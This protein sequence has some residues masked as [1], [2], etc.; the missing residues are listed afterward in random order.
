MVSPDRK[1]CSVQYLVSRTPGRHM[2]VMH[3]LKMEYAFFF[4]Y[5]HVGLYHQLLEVGWPEPDRT[6]SQ[7][8]ENPS[9]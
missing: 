8:L 5:N 9:R 6:K 2:V 3:V 4:S 7:E 1:G